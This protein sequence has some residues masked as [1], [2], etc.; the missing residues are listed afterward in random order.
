MAIRP[1]S[2][3]SAFAGNPYL[4]SPALLLED[5]LLTGEDLSDRPDF[6]TEPGGLWRGDSLE[7]D[8]SGTCYV[9]FQ[10]ECNRPEIK[11]EMAQLPG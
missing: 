2:A 9:R 4:V 6:P 8:S 7:A 3:F 10:E 5:D 11:A 1:T